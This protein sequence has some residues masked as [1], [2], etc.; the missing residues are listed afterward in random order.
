MKGE[1]LS[2]SKSDSHSSK[3]AASEWGSIAFQSF[4]S[5][6]G[7]IQ[8]VIESKI[9]PDAIMKLHSQWMDMKKIELSIPNLPSVS[10]LDLRLEKIEH[11]RTKW[12]VLEATSWSTYLDTVK[13]CCPQ[14][15]IKFQTDG[16]SYYCIDCG[17]QCDEEFYR[18]PDKQLKDGT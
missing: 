8:T 3:P 16:I 18:L 2:S 9:S 11:D 4:E 17:F 7:P 15:G 14:C 1:S 13:P 6:K 5:G 10:D 12:D